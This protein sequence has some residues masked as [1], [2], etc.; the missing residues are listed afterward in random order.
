VERSIQLWEVKDAQ[1]LD[2]NLRSIVFDVQGE[3][4]LKVK[5][6]TFVLHDLPLFREFIEFLEANRARLARVN[7]IDFDYTTENH[8]MCGLII[9][10]NITAETVRPNAEPDFA[11]LIE[12]TIGRRW[13]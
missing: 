5:P 8:E 10:L 13:E 1:P 11:D 4:V 3:P 12:R 6:L 2:D 7:G 9:R